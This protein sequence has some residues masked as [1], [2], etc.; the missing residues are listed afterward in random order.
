VVS[1]KIAWKWRATQLSCARRSG[2]FRAFES[3][4]QPRKLED[5][6]R[7]HEVVAEGVRDPQQISARLK[8]MF[9][10]EQDMRVSHET[11]YQALFV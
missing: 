10:D 5:N 1:R 9:P 6:R 3:A 8:E 7:L 2:T 4:P 11:T